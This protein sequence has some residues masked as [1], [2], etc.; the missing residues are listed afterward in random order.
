MSFWALAA[1]GGMRTFCNREPHKLEERVGCFHPAWG[2][3]QAGGAEEPGEGVLENTGNKTA[4]LA[5]Q[6][7][8]QALFPPLP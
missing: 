7:G 5:S 1:V 2:G 8:P 4:M 6:A 3:N